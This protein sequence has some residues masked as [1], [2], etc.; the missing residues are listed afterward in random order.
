MFFTEAHLAHQLKN[1]L[2]ADARFNCT[3]ASNYA[4]ANEALDQ[5]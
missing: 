5:L 4:D 1:V 3:I 2:H